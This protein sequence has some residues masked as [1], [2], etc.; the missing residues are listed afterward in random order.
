MPRLANWFSS[1]ARS[2]TFVLPMAKTSNGVQIE[3]A[4]FVIFYSCYYGGFTPL[5]A[6]NCE[7]LVFRKARHGSSLVNLRS[8]DGSYVQA[9]IQNVSFFFFFWT[10]LIIKTLL[11][12]FMLPMLDGIRSGNSD[13]VLMYTPEYNF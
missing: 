8:G 11:K 13:Y 10:A 7:F 6:D 2:S 5:S 4:T 9:A 12:V 1:P 3:K